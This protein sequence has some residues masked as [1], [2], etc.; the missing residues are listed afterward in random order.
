[1]GKA[2]IKGALWGGI[3]VF[4]WGF[5]SWGLIPWHAMA[6]KK[7]HNQGAISLLIRESA[8][9][10]GIYLLPDPMAAKNAKEK[11]EIRQDMKKGPFIFASVRLEGCSMS[12]LKFVGSLIMDLVV[13]FFITWLL[14]HTKGMNYGKKVGFVT[15][16]G[17]IAAILGH[18][19]AWNWWGF[20]G[21]FVLVGM[22]DVVI[23]WFLAGLVMARFARP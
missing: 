6:F 4:I 21:S 14:L 17:L 1:M 10:S 8:P 15:M 11:A 13:A 16:V 19:P 5:I 2:L 22:V 18:F 20:P 7:F 23:G 3:V 12:V 9:S